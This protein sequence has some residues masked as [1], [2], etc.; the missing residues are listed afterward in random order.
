MPTTLQQHIADKNNPHQVTKEQAGLGEIEN[1]PLATKAEV[2]ALEAEDRYVDINNIE[3]INEAFIEYLKRIGL[4]DDNGDLL[5]PN[6]EAGLFFD[7]SN[8]GQ[9]SLNGTSSNATKVTVTLLDGSG[10]IFHQVSD[11]PITDINGNWTV[12]VSS[13]AFNPSETYTAQVQ[14]FNDQGFESDL[15]SVDAMWELPIPQATIAFELS[16]Y[17]VATLNGTAAE[18][19]TVE[20]TIKKPGNVVVFN[21]T[22]T[23][24]GDQ[25]QATMEGVSF[26]PDV[27]YTATAKPVN[28]IGQEGPVAS[29]T[30]TYSL[31]LPNMDTPVF[32][33]TE[34]GVGHLSG[35]GTDMVSVDVEIHDE[36]N[37]VVFSG[38]KDVVDG[39]WA[40]DLSAVSFMFDH[41]YTAHVTPYNASGVSNDTQQVTAI[42]ED[43]GLVDHLN[44][45]NPHNVTKEQIGLGDVE[46]YAMATESE[47]I[48]GHGERYIAPGMVMALVDSR[49][50]DLG[51]YEYYGNGGN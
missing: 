13:L 39:S 25:W 37:A 21:D 27:Q 11:L 50:S 12:D 16:E 48:M 34:M 20:V 14:G 32:N 35:H 22:L 24:N 30:A 43:P 3:W 51:V 10:S 44:A 40:A 7:L 5:K 19:Q 17:G 38:T 6:V 45:I 31:P 33:L 8:D 2:I 1:F 23:L 36:T 9:G 47:A 4:A 26:N 29:T 46:N 28:Y 15:A 41:T 18:A 49:L 42:Y